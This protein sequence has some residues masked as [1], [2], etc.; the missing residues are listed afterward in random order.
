MLSQS[1]SA[2]QELTQ[3]RQA[4]EQGDIQ[5]AEAICL[6]R[7]VENPNDAATLHLGSQLLLR[8]GKVHGA[9]ERL[10]RAIELEPEQADWM[11]ELGSLLAQH[12]QPEHAVRF[13]QHALLINPG[14]GMVWNH[15]GAMR[16]KLG[17]VELACEAFE[18]A[19]IC[20]ENL[21]DAWANYANCL[22]VMGRTQ[23]A[24]E[25]ILRAFVAAPDA[26]QPRVLRGMALARLG[27]IDDAA[28]CYHQHLKQYPADPAASHLLAALGIG[29]MPSH[30]SNAYIMQKYA[31]YADSY[32]HHQ[33]GMHY[34]GGQLLAEAVTHVGKTGDKVLDAG[35]G[36]G[37]VGRYLAGQ[38]FQL[39]GV[40]LSA[41]M[42][43]KAE[44]YSCYHRLYHADIMDFMAKHPT[45]YDVITAADLLIYHGD[46]RDWLAASQACLRPAGWLV[47]TLEALDPADPR[48][49]ALQT[50]G[51]FRHGQTATEQTLQQA[52][53]EH[54]SIRHATL[55]NEGGSPLACLVVSASRG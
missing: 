27:R 37:Q 12:D 53:F 26:E 17:E 42:L 47:M 51:R 54:I 29:P 10:M 48:P 18:Q 11:S 5:Q 23:E 38:G 25:C 3:A 34:A 46:L 13:F 44:E 49:F 35:C 20:D 9:I 19:L 39:T 30:A 28:D 41:E 15:L 21:V 22:T 2:T 8:Q 16:F 1:A 36:T 45:G 52:G 43:Q 24:T 4:L 33:A 32:D 55:R 50:T 14:N 31:D 40:D 7:L 6:Q